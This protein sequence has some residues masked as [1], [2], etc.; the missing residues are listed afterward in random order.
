M[1][2][3]QTMHIQESHLALYHIYCYI[4]ERQLNP[5]QAEAELQAQ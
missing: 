1:T 2:S 5:E 4:V 3:D